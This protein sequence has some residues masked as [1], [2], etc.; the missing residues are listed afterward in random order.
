[1]GQVI[2]RNIDD[3]VIE[4]LRSGAERANKPL[5]QSLREILGEAARADKAAVLERLRRLAAMNPATAID[6]TDLI[7]EDRDR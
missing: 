5:E 1:M 2:I 4:S 3:A 7:R 6:A